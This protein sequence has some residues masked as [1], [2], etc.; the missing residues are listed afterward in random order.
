[1]KKKFFIIA[2]VL[3][4]SFSLFACS[5]DNSQSAE[6]EAAAGNT[7]ENSET[8]ENSEGSAASSDELS[9]KITTNAEVGKRDKLIVTAK[10]ENKAI[11]DMEIEV[12]FYDGDG[13]IVG[14]ASEDFY[15]VGSGGEVAIELYDTPEKFDSYKV[16]AD[17]EPTTCTS[18][19]DKV[20]LNH[21]DSGEQVAVQLTNES[22]DEIQALEIC[23]VYYREGKIVGAVDSSESDVKA[24]RS[25]N[26]NVDYPVSKNYEN[27]RFDKYKVFINEVYSW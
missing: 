27:V 22:E 13:I 24:G 17:A 14:S 18:Y 19:Y 6:G 4:L 7:V 1:M 15:G 11:I 25:A 23:V 26:F 2:G 16:F 9:K 20:K 5:G 3:V 21:N 8:S 10:N 12:E